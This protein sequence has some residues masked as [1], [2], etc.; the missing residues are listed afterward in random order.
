M[1]VTLFAEGDGG[2]PGVPSRWS[3]AHAAPGRRARSCYSWF[4][5]VIA[6][7][8]HGELLG[9]HLVGAEVAELLPELTL[10]QRWDLTV[11]ELVRNVHTHPTLS[12]ALQETFHGLAADMINF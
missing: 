9:G 2:G 4:A 5:K 12:E 11:D 10:A 7:T 3:L 1:V 8:A 6:D